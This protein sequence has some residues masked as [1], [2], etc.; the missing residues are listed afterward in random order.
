ML[1]EV[2]ALELAERGVRVNAVSPGLV[3]TP[4]TAGIA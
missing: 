3:D 1:V 4:L 2:A